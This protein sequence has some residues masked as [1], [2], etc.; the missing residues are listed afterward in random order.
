MKLM[1]A[2]GGM[3]G[4]PAVPPAPAIHVAAATSESKRQEINP[5]QHDGVRAIYQG[6]YYIQRGLEHT[7]SEISKI[8]DVTLYMRGID[9]YGPDQPYLAK[10][11]QLADNVVFLDPVPMHELVSALS[12]FD[13]GL[14]PY[15]GTNFN[16]INASPNKTFEY[17]MAGLAVVS[18]ELPVQREILNECGSGLT[19]RHEIEGDIAHAIRE[20]IRN[21]ET[22]KSNAKRCAKNKYN[23]NTQGGKLIDIYNRVIS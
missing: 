19:Y 10:L 14:M 4:A 5:I 6:R 22:H 7:I 13:I 9:S 12:E 21:L 23:W 20:T 8:P 16:N 17:M 11:K 15:E 3:V 1:M 2:N 18:S